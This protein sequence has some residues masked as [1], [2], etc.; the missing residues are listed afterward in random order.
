MAGHGLDAAVAGIDRLTDDPLVGD[1]MAALQ[2]LERLT[3]APSDRATLAMPLGRLID[4][5]GRETVLGAVEIDV[6]LHLPGVLEA[7]AGKLF[8]GNEGGHLVIPTRIAQ[9]LTDE[10]RAAIRQLASLLDQDDDR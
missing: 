7:L 4:A 2:S 9:R 10:G 1:T 8:T 3:A 5:D 6:Q